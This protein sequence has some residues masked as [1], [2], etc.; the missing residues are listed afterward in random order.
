MLQTETNASASQAVAITADRADGK[1][2][3]SRRPFGRVRLFGC[4]IDRATMRQAVARVYDW[5]AE[6]G[7]LCRY[8]VTPNVDHVVMLQEHEGLRRA[9]DDASMVLADGMPVVLA[10]RLLGKPLPERVTGA[11]LV[12]QLFAA[13]TARGPLRVFLLGAGP[14]VAEQAAHKIA[15]RFPAVDV[16]GTYCPPLGFER[17]ASENA[18]I[19]E[20]I[21]AGRPDV[22]VVG[23]GAPK[24]ELWVHRHRQHI[25]ATV[26]L[27]VGATIDFLA[28]HKRRAPVW[29][30]RSGLE[31]LHRVAT[32]PRR[33]FMRYAR[34]A[35]RFPGIVWRERRQGRRRT[36]RERMASQ[37]AN[38]ATMQPTDD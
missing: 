1:T 35:W 13:S 31:W 7:R 23:L 14:G 26:A 24:Q 11:D 27:C 29:M 34:D 30:Q 15:S 10:S 38:L 22:L 33:L 9:Y 12:T 3:A 32:E 37:E 18:K 25:R 21:A 8:V 16:V 2:V 17:D 19:L 36:N 6:P 5:I 4:R 20:M 28:E